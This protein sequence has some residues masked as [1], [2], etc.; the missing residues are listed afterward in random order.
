[1]AA[2]KAHHFGQGPAASDRISDHR[3]EYAHRVRFIIVAVVG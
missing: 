3:P 1:V 2:Y